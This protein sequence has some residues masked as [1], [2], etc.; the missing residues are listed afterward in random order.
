MANYSYGQLKNPTNSAARNSSISF[1]ETTTV[2]NCS[3][4]IAQVFWNWKGCNRWLS[5]AVLLLPI[6]KNLSNAMTAVW[7]CSRLSKRNWAV[8]CSRVCWVFQLTIGIIG[9]GKKLVISNHFPNKFPKFLRKKSQFWFTVHIP[10][11][12]R[13]GEK[14]DSFVTHR[15]FLVTLSTTLCLS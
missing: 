6:P 1:T 10:R 2:S 13:R 14:G 7:N 5:R 4:G 11:P 12:W 15:R 3:H 8:A 9:H